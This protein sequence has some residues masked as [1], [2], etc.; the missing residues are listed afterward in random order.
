MNK[1]EFIKQVCGDLVQTMQP[2]TPRYTNGSWDGTEMSFI[3][4]TG[5]DNKVYV[6]DILNN[7]PMESV[8]GMELDSAIPYCAVILQK[9]YGKDVPDLRDERLDRL[10]SFVSAYE[11]FSDRCEREVEDWIKSNGEVKLEME[12]YHYQIF[13]MQGRE[14]SLDSAFI[15]DN[16]SVCVRCILVNQGDGKR[17]PI[18]FLSFSDISQDPVILSDFMR[19]FYR[20]TE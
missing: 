18:D 6:I 3:F 8:N 5:T 1:R 11:K 20:I 16:G 4:M 19:E 15:D 7:K 14:C 13:S 2:M 10:N 17:S 9:Y 12:D